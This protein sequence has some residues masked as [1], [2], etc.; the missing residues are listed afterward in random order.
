MIIE[1]FGL[2]KV[3]L[4]FAFTFLFASQLLAQQSVKKLVELGDEALIAHHYQ[5]AIEYFA[6]AESKAPT[7]PNIKYQL[8]ECYRY[9]FQYAKAEQY[10][11]Q[12]NSSRSKN[13]PLVLFYLAL[14]QKMNNKYAEAIKTFDQFILFAQAGKFAGKDEMIAQTILEKNGCML[15]IER[16]S[17]PFRSI[18]LTHLPAPVNTEFNDY[19]PF[20][21]QHDS[22]IVITSSRTESTDKTD[23]SFGEGFTDCIR[24]TKESGS[25]TPLQKDDDFDKTNGDVHEGSG[26]FNHDFTKYYF[27]RCNGPECA[28]FYTKIQN[29]K[30]LPEEKLNTN[31]NPNGSESKHP[32]LSMSGDTLFFISNRA[33]GFGGN[34]V[35]MSVASGEN[36]WGP[37]KNLGNKINTAWM[38]GSPFYF[39]K[40]K[41]IYYVLNF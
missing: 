19:A 2:R 41:I 4:F 38:E 22:I 26:S 28:I 30:W 17:L 29:G 37:V 40:E 24:F 31:I 34:D 9:T 15:A 12:V 13:H 7:D 5:S 14:T 3:Y 35:Y 32:A 33:G 21:Y 36:Q 8:A 16:S 27:T 18:K 20:T 6:S 25:W 11:Q 1:R 23:I 10:Y 39:S